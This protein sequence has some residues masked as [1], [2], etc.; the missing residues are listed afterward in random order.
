MSH[1]SKDRVFAGEVS[2]YKR[3]YTDK[4]WASAYKNPFVGATIYGSNLGN[5]EILGYGFGTYALSN[6]RFQI[7]RSIICQPNWEPESAT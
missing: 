5:E 2:V 3:I 7:L 4:K 1:L 6:F